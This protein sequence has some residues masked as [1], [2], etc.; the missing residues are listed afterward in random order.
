MT[1]R[2]DPFTI[3][4]ALEKTFGDLRIEVASDVTGRSKAYLR[5]LYHPAK[6]PHLTV[7]DMVK[8]TLASRERGLGTPIWDTVA[9][10]VRAADATYFS[11]PAEIGRIAVDVIREGGEA[12]A[13]LCRV[14][15]PGAS[16][17]DFTDTLRQIE[18]SVHELSHAAAIVSAELRVRKGEPPP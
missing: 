2:R 17:A 4:N 10:I 12:H 7:V 9:A 6:R 8:L 14:S 1:L 18:E 15:Q 5:A 16:V 11:G 3:E 13:A